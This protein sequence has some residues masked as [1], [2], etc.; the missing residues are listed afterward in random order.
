MDGFIVVISP[1]L[2]NQVALPILSKLQLVQLCGVLHRTIFLN[3]RVLVRGA[4]ELSRVPTF[5]I[6]EIAKLTLDIIFCQKHY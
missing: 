5:D 6:I 1:E 3:F 4:R 2:R